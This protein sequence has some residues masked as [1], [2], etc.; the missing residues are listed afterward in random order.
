MSLVQKQSRL[1][2]LRLY[3]VSQEARRMKHRAPDAHY[4]LTMN[5]KMPGPKQKHVKNKEHNTKAQYTPGHQKYVAA[6]VDAIRSKN[7]ERLE[8]NCKEDIF[9]LRQIDLT[10]LES[11]M[12]SLKTKGFLRAYKPYTPPNDLKQR[13][14]KS[15]QAILGESVDWDKLDKIPLDNTDTKFSILF[16]LSKEFGHSVHNSRLHEMVTLAEVLLFYEYPIDTRT[17][18]EQLHAQAE[19]GTLPANICIQLDPH[20]F[21]GKGDHL[22]DKVTAWPRSNTYSNRNIYT[23]DKY[24]PLKAATHYWHEDDYE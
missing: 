19:D 21:T 15:C 11:Q 6:Q 12:Q 7:K 9:D 22:L 3:S 20:R 4:H 14:L 18:Y 1:A 23:R 13:F 5:Y 24:P 10:S 17:P 16:S 8:E 2:F